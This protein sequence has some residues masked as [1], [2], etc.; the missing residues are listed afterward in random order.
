MRLARV[1][2]TWATHAADIDG[3]GSKEIRWLENGY[4]VSVTTLTPRRMM[5]AINRNFTRLA[6]AGAGG[7]SGDGGIWYFGGEDGEGDGGEDTFG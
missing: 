5:N 4:T 3:L 7:S 6:A 2:A 1:E